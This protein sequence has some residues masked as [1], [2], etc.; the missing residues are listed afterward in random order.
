MKNIA[1]FCGSAKG[2][3]K[4]YRQAAS[5]LAKEMAEASMDLVYGGGSIGLMGIIADELIALDRKVNQLESETSA[6]GSKRAHQNLPSAPRP[7][8]GQP[9]HQPDRHV[10]GMP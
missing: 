1:V 3:D 7:Q 4:A 10:H 5:V 2:K 8:R 6:P 9:L